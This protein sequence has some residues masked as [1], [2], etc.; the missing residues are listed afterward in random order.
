MRRGRQA[1]IRHGQL[2]PWVV[3]PYGYVLD[4]DHPRDPQGMRLHPVT[5]VVVEQIFARFTD[6]QAPLTLYQ[7]AK[8]LTASQIPTPKG[9][10]RWNPSTVRN[11]LRSP[12]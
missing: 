1:R 3:A 7:G 10:Q 6:V 8:R 9:K 4:A 12:L 11:I 2:L 5:S